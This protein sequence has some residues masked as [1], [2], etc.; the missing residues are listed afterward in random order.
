MRRIITFGTFDSFHEGHYNILKRAKEY[1]G[2]HNFLIVGVSSDSLNVVK[3]KQ[4]VNDL[5]TRMSDVKKTGF[6]DIIFVEESLLDKQKYVDKYNADLLIM[7]DDWKGHFDWINIPCKYLSRTDNVSTTLLDIKQ[8]TSV[9]KYRFLFY[10]SH[11]TKHM[12]YYNILKPYCERFNVEYAIY[13]ENTMTSDDVNSYDLIIQF[14]KVL[15]KQVSKPTVIIDHGASNLKW[16][17]SDVERYLSVDYFF[18]AGPQHKDS[19]EAFFGKNDNIISTGF[20]KSRQLFEKPICDKDTLSEKY[21]FDKTKPLI[22]Y[23]PTW[24]T[25]IGEQHIIRE[26]LANIDNLILSFHPEDSTQHMFDGKR[27]DMRTSELIKVCDVIISDHSSILFES[28]VLNKKN[29]Q[30][31]LNY[32]SDNPARNYNYPLT[33]GTCRS[34]VGGITTLP[35]NLRQTIL[36]INTIPQSVFDVIYYNLARISHIW[37]DVPDTI[38]RQLLIIADKPKPKPKQITVLK[39]ESKKELITVNDINDALFKRLK[40]LNGTDIDYDIECDRKCIVNEQ[41]FA[42]QS[43]G[44]KITLFGYFCAYINP[45]L[46]FIANATCNSSCTSTDL[47]LD[48]FLLSSFQRNY[49][50]TMLVSTN[51]V[52]RVNNTNVFVSKVIKIDD[53]YYSVSACPYLVKKINDEYVYCNEL[54]KM[55]IVKDYTFEYSTDST[56]ITVDRYQYHIPNSL[57]NNDYTV[58]YHNFVLISANNLNYYVI[59]PK[60]YKNHKLYEKG[61]VQEPISYDTNFHEYITNKD[62]VAMQDNKDK[63]YEKI[64]NMLGIPKTTSLVGMDIPDDKREMIIDWIEM[65][66]FDQTNTETRPGLT[67]NLTKYTLHD[68]FAYLA[69][70]TIKKKIQ[71]H[72]PKKSFPITMSQVDVKIVEPKLEYLTNKLKCNL[73]IDNEQINFGHRSGW[74]YV[75][76]LIANNIDLDS[77]MPKV[78]LVDLIEKTFSWDYMDKDGI[79]TI[80]FMGKC[81]DVKYSE[82]KIKNFSGTYTHLTKVNDQYIVW[83][84]DRWVLDIT[85]KDDHYKERRSV[86]DGI[87]IQEPWIGIWHNPHNMPTWFNYEHSPQ[88]ILKRQ[89]FIESLK[90][91]KGII[92][93]SEYFKKWLEQQISI[94]ISVLFHP[95]EPSSLCF[96]FQKFLD[97]KEKCII[98]VGYWLR[99]LNSITFITNPK[100]A[101]VWLYGNVWAFTCLEAEGKCDMKDVNIFNLTNEEYDTFLSKNICL[102]NVYDSSANNA[103]IECIVRHTPLIVNKHPAIVEYLGEKYPLYFDDMKEVDGMLDNIDLLRSGHEYLKTNKDIQT[104]ISG[105]YFIEQFSKLQL[106]H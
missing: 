73:I 87:V 35:I 75:L 9:K 70:C 1:D 52:V 16:F 10:D 66:F 3:K 25:L 51:T 23:A 50:D 68:Q 63:L 48:Y 89:G 92:V 91:C 103:V 100:Y 102:V 79:K 101:K 47:V 17:L 42:L 36:N 95:T 46:Q 93:L 39:K 41:F 53:H 96:D 104:R 60:S 54:V 43:F 78:R 33:A 61:Y 62:I 8:R 19:M 45:Y 88:S 98:Q 26:Q 15:H 11:C 105:K 59:V 82:L 22:L 18:V 72:D 49:D 56:C 69:T 67:T 44:K 38:F 74:K 64:S 13:D 21:G 94:P 71:T 2:R 24:I 28:A 37:K 90:S 57:I 76:S 31:L 5:T 7:G 86:T 77:K 32:Y 81:H 97:N 99:Q 30:I 58:V 85:E 83:N 34:F 106:V 40:Y 14:N 4:S 29:I 80:E 12:E 6:A 55:K 65:S 27:V 84:K 20:V